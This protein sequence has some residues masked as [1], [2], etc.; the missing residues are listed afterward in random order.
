MPNKNQMTYSEKLKDPRWQKL[1][2]EIMQLDNF[3]CQHCHSTTKT[4]NIHHVLYKRGA[5]PWEYEPSLL[6]TLCET[7]HE[8]V[9]WLKE[10]F[11]LIVGGAIGPDIKACGI[12]NA[13]AFIK[14][15]VENLKSQEST[16]ALTK[17]DD[18]PGLVVTI[19]RELLEAC[20]TEN[21]GFTGAT[22]NALG[23]TKATMTKGWA[24]R[25]IGSSITKE[26]YER[27]LEGK[28]VY[29]HKLARN[30]INSL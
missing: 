12:C 21:G 23:L 28:T 25:L 19:T 22:V 13:L 10:K 16:P 1:R 27:A 7:C 11:A 5:M 26:Q 3:Q 15:F 8:Q 20:R 2:L 24:K 17:C 14:R 4:L 30:P 9:K 29:G 6:V 18:E